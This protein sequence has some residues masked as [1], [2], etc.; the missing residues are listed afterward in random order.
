MPSPQSIRYQP[1][2]LLS[3]RAMPETFLCLVGTP[4]EVPRK[5]RFIVLR[6]WPFEGD[7]VEEVAPEIRLTSEEVASADAAHFLCV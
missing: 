3:R 2:P 4:A 5:S 6:G 1:F 7:D